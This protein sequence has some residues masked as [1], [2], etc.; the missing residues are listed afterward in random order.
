VATRGEEAVRT[1][2]LSSVI[3]VRREQKANAALSDF[4]QKG[5]SA[6]PAASVGLRRNMSMDPR[7]R[8]PER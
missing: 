1:A 2:T 6:T 7:A 5:R 8:A 4:N 3:P